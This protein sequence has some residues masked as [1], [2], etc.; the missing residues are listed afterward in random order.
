MFVLTILLVHVSGFPESNPF[1]VDSVAKEDH[2]WTIKLKNHHPFVPEVLN[3]TNS[4]NQE[5]TQA[6]VHVE[7]ADMRVLHVRVTDSTAKRWEAPL[8]NPR[9]GSDYKPAGM[10]QMGFAYSNDPFAFWVDDPESQQQLLSTEGRRGGSLRYFDKFVELG[11][12]YPSQRLF[13]CG[14]RSMPD[15]EL[16]HARRICKYTIFNRDALNPVD[17]GEPPGAKHTYGSHPFYMM[18]LPSGLFSGAFFLNS[19]AQEVEIVRIGDAVVNLYHRSV[20]GIID[21]YFFYPQ[22]A[23]QLMRK[24]HDLIGRPAVPPFWALGFHQC[25]WGWQTLDAVREV[26]ARYD[27]ADIPLEA[28]WADIDYMQDKEDFTYDQER[29]KGLPGFVSELHRRKMRWVPILDAGVKYDPESKYITKGEE[30]DAFIRSAVYPGETFIGRVWP[31]TT[32][33]VDFFSPRGS[34]LWQMGLSDLA[35][36]VDFD[37]LWLDMNEPAN[38]CDGECTEGEIWAPEPHNPSEFENLGFV[39]GEVPLGRMAIHMAAYYYAK[40][41]EEEK[42]HKEFNLHN[43][44]SIMECRSSFEFL[45]KRGRRPFLLTRASYPGSGM[46]TA[47][48]GGDNY[49]TWEFLRYS[50]ISIYNFQLFGMPM[51]GTDICGFK[52]HTNEEL[53]ARWIQSGAFYPFARNHNDINGRDQELYSFNSRLSTTARNALRQRYSLLQYYYTNIFEASLF[54]G[55]VF[56]P[57]FFEFPNDTQAY[58]ERNDTFLVGKSILVAPALHKGVRTVSPYL[59]NGNWYDLRAGRLLARYLENEMNGTRV[60]LKAGF[61]HVNVLLRGGAVIPFQDAAAAGVRR[62]ETLHLLPLEIIVAPDHMGH[63]HGTLVVDDGESISPVENGTYRHYSFDFANTEKEREMTVKIMHDYSAH[64]AFERFRL[65]TVL[66][67]NR[68]EGFETACIEGEK[69]KTLDEVAG[70]YDSAKRAYTYHK[71]RAAFYWSDIRKIRFAKK[72]GK[73]KTQAATKQITP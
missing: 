17:M 71:A 7:S 15:F 61:E 49:S 31:G 29:F 43:L 45:S 16:C 23:E 67:T 59:P 11:L 72:C 3:S 60:T 58:L 57:L 8:F 5:I 70:T 26:A 22:G 13:G 12:W 52:G 56:S 40:N 62:T 55:A 38:F 47:I 1:Y 46:Y 28:L 18:M 6:T 19:N 73:G 35:E 20:G 64:F 14:E 51:A 42:F 25:R 48:W 39:P 54:G 69:N 36:M 24:Y 53:C 63:A 50:I 4:T 21:I 27:A 65:L 34:E 32:A 68:T 33:F 30:M 66:G 10:S 9:V 2:V 37:G 44:W 41:K